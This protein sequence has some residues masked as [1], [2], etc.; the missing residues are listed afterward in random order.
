MKV[1][2]SEFIFEMM[3]GVRKR[4]KKR[5]TAKTLSWRRREMGLKGGG[6]AREVEDEECKKSEKKM[7]KCR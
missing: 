2:R 6:V 3:R 7:A 4:K 1:A 5:K